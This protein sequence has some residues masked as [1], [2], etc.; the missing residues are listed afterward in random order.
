MARQLQSRQE[1]LAITQDALRTSEEHHRLLAENTTDMIT[2]FDP[3]FER[4]YVS[5]ASKELLG[6]TQQE[7]VGRTPLEIVHPDDHGIME[8]E[9]HGP[10]KAGQ[11]AAIATFRTQRKDGAYRWTEVSGRRLPDGGGYVVITRDVTERKVIEQQLEEANRRLEQLAM[12]DP[13]TGLPNRR[14]LEDLLNKEFRRST[15]LRRPISLIM[16]DVDWFKAY[17]DAYGHPAG[18]SCLRL[19]AGAI[20]AVLRQPVDLVARMGGEEFAVL[21]PNTTRDDALHVA[22][23]VR[24]AVRDLELPHRGSPLSIVTISL[25]VETCSPHQEGMVESMLLSAADKALYIAKS[26]GRDCVCGGIE[27]VPAL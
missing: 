1:Q 3:N 20:S 27:P 24:L 22:E 23:R 16:I 21:L 5:P 15:R 19:I 12:Q 25:G 7:L 13:L 26:G 2:R 17:N 4:I 10:L 11:L 14:R 18:D 8:A 9:L 6:Y